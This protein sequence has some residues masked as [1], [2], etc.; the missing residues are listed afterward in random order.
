MFGITKG[1]IAQQF[2]DALVRRSEAGVE[3]RLIV[4]YYGAKVDSQS[5]PYFE[6]MSAAGIEIVVNNVFPVD[7]DGLFGDLSIDWRQDEVGQSD[8]RKAMVVDGR[9]G[10]V[11]GAG[12]QDHFNGGTFHDTFVRVEG[13]VVRQMQAAFLTSFHSFGGPLSGDPG[14]LEAYFPA[15]EDPGTIRTTLLQNIPG[16]FLPG[17]QASQAII[18]AATTRLD[19]MNPY[20]TDAGMLDRILD[21]AERGVQVR[22]LVSAK[23]NNEP[24]DAALKHEYGRLLDAGVEIWEYPVTMH[25]KVTI[26]DDAMIVGTINYDAW[27]LYRNLEIALLFENATVA[28]EGVAHF[29]EPDIERSEPGEAP[30]GRIERLKGWFWDKLTYF[31]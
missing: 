8:H 14:S 4:D 19:I 5:K 28:N 10:W 1:D 27:A 21:A 31:L 15:P 16:G 12:F 22:L 23:S 29:V 17:T 24:A 18:E 26:A 11:G 9:I 13:N 30:D 7:R 20:F 3:V 25:A 6:A 2:S